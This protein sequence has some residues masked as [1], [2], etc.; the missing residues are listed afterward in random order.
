MLEGEY[1]EGMQSVR[2]WEQNV[3][4]QGEKSYGL[5]LRV[6]MTMHAF[7]QQS[8]LPLFPSGNPPQRLAVD[9]GKK[10]INFCVDPH[11]LGKLPVL[12]ELRHI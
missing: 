12:G 8:F 7:S 4:V 2:A 3:C 11:L 9:D 5:V 10:N 6:L 1:C